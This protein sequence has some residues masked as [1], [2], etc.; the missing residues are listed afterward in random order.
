MNDITLRALAIL[1]E[2]DL[3]AAED[4]R[5]TSRLLN[6]HLI[7]KQLISYHEHNEKKRAPEL[8]NRLNRGLQ[9]ALVSNAGTPSVS[10][11]GYHLIK[12]AIE[13]S[14]KIIPIP[15]ACAAIT[16]LSGTAIPGGEFVFV[17][18]LTRKKEKRLKRL[19]KLADE[20]R[21]IVFYESPNRIL[22]LMEEI[23][24]IMGDRYCTLSR[25]LTKIHEE[26]MRGTVPEIISHIKKLTALKG[27]CTLIVS[28]SMQNKDIS[29]ETLQNEIRKR[30]AAKISLSD[31]AKEIAAK[32]GLPKSKV[33]GEALK[34]KRT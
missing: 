29:I 26:F 3:I 23:A 16:A 18:F 17:G 7:K 27:E 30:L 11:P 20:T 19:K 2:V 1:K 32:Y 8:I 15:G 4:T 24:L 31:L 10:D 28:G 5:H 9:I 13:N 22:T 34:I 14:I 6:Y 33:Y 25:E 12:K 21:T